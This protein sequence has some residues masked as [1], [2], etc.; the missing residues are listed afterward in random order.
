VGGTA[1][2][3]DSPPPGGNRDLSGRALRGLAQTGLGVAAQILVQIVAVAFL[4]RLLTPEDFGVVA[5]A[6]IVIM[7]SRLFAD[8]A[9][10]AAI[11]QRPEIG[12]LHVRSAFT[13]SLGVGLC[14]VA[15]LFFGADLVAGALRVERAAD[16]LRGLAV[17]F[18]SHGLS[19][20]AENL[21]LR[22]LRFGALARINAGATILCNGVLAVGLAF[23]GFGFWSLV[24][25]AVAH[26]AVRAVWLLKTARHDLRPAFHLRSL[27]E[28]LSLGAGFSMGRLINF[29]A[30]Q[31]DSIVIARFFGPVALGLYERSAR[32]AHIPSVFYDQVMG[33]VAFS[34]MSRAQDDLVRMRTAMRR[35]MALTAL[36]GFPFSVAMAVVGP[37][38][39]RLFLGETWTS[40]I[41]LFQVFVFATFIK[42]AYRVSQAI[43]QARGRVYVF[44][45][46]QCVFATGVFGGSFLAAPHGILAVAGTITGMT[47]LNLTVLTA[48]AMREIGMPLRDL[49]RCCGPGA[50]NGALLGGL[51][52]GAAA[53]IRPQGSDAMTIAVCAAVISIYAAAIYFA[54]AKALWGADGLWLRREATS[55][56]RNALRRGR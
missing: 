55:M 30:I 31:G 13:L 1:V 36:L 54:P 3:D 47:F 45:V 11:T 32:L 44:A 26:S 35:G 21:L 2:K 41:P 6:N 18:L 12:P 52:V 8:L 46:A 51:L 56:V 50:L 23:A 29:F 19:S 9:M 43:I 48:I 14:L 4:A 5:A 27:R 42:L 7:F 34:S 24:I 17:V 37:E 40:A 53:F 38:I 15:G 10:G 25:G 39:I 16:A 20:V 28:L 22:E 49:V 33:A